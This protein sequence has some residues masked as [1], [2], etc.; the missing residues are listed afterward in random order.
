M[1]SDCELQGA[2]GAAGMAWASSHGI[3]DTRVIGSCVLRI[4]DGAKCR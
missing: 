2:A 4:P 3:E 1:I